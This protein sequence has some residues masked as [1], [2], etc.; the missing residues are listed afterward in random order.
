MVRQ[1]RR[2]GEIREQ[3]LDD[4]S[5]PARPD[6]VRGCPGGAARQ[7]VRARAGRGPDPERRVD[8][9]RRDFIANVSHE[10]KT[11]VGALILLAEAVAEAADDPEAVQR[12]SGP[13]ADRERAG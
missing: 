12:F 11:P 5:R 10:L 2:D 7:P 4:A 1:V 9:I 3:D 8:A 6:A 13:D